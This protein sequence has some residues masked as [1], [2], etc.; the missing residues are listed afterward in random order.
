MIVFNY[1]YDRTPSVVFGHT[2]THG[3]GSANKT[4]HQM[5]YYVH[6]YIYCSGSGWDAK[7]GVSF[8]LYGGINLCSTVRLCFSLQWKIDF[9]SG[10]FMTLTLFCTPAGCSRHNTA[11][12]KLG[13]NDVNMTTSWHCCFLWYNAC[14]CLSLNE[15]ENLLIFLGKIKI[16]FTRDHRKSYFHSWLRHSWKYNVLLSMI[17]REINYHLS[18]ANIQQYLHLFYYTKPPK[19]TQSHPLKS[20]LGISKLKYN[21]NCWMRD[22][23]KIFWCHFMSFYNI[24]VSRNQHSKYIL[25]LYTKPHKPLLRPQF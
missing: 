20:F 1:W 16:Y 3:L 5:F 14:G 12:I 18:Y 21:F 23:Y 15:T 13:T 24:I 22:T 7:K 11:F 2:I 25:L 10:Y 8:M 9:F 17:T 4:K 19:I 6:V